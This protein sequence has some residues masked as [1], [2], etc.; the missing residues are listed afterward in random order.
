M[1]VLGGS[2]ALVLLGVVLGSCRSAPPTY[3]ERVQI[4]VP[5]PT[6]S[7]EVSTAQ[8]SEEADYEI[9]LMSSNGLIGTVGVRLLEPTSEHHRR[10]V[11][12][13]VGREVPVSLSNDGIVLLGKLPPEKNKSTP[14]GRTRQLEP[15]TVALV[16]WWTQPL[17]GIWLRPSEVTGIEPVGSVVVGHQFLE[18]LEQLQQPDG[19]L[20]G[21]VH[22]IVRRR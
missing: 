19:T 3:N 11:E 22:A 1:R 13:I 14:E 17:L 4:T 18:S 2:G 12:G 21:T 9:D 8:S 20:S 6:A 15:G 5:I 16:Q 10:I 7:V